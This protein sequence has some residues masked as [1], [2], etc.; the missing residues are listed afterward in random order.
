MNFFT[1]P[2]ITEHQIIYVIK[3]EDDWSLCKNPQTSQLGYVPTGYIQLIVKPQ[4]KPPNSQQRSPN[5]TR[6]NIQPSE[7]PNNNNSVLSTSSSSTNVKSLHNIEQSQ[8]QFVG[9]VN[10]VN[11]PSSSSFTINVEQFQNR[12]TEPLVDSSISIRKTKKN[13]QQGG[14]SSPRNS[15]NIFTVG[16]PSNSGNPH[17]GKTTK[18]AASISASTQNNTGG[19]VTPPG[20]DYPESVD[21]K[22][23]NFTSVKERIKLL[24]EQK[25]SLTNVAGSTVGNSSLTPNT[26]TINVSKTNTTTNA[27]TTINH[28]IS[29][30][31]QPVNSTTAELKK[32]M[33]QTQLN[34]TANTA[35]TTTSVSTSGMTPREKNEKSSTP[36]VTSSNEK[37]STPQNNNNSSAVTTPHVSIRPPKPKGYQNKHGEQ[38]NVSTSSTTPASSTTTNTGIHSVSQT[39][40]GSTPPMSN[41]AMLSTSPTSTFLY[42]AVPILPIATKTQPSR[43]V[44]ESYNMSTASSLENPSDQ[45]GKSPQDEKKK[46]SIKIGRGL[47]KALKFNKQPTHS[48]PT[49]PTNEDADDEDALPNIPVDSYTKSTN[50]VDSSQPH[51]DIPSPALHSHTSSEASIIVKSN[52][53][54][55]SKDLENPEVSDKRKTLPVN[56]KSELFQKMHSQLKLQPGQ[57]PMHLPNNSTS[58]GT[59]SSATTSSTI[60][61][62]EENDYLIVT[63]PPIVKPM[64]SIPSQVQRDY[65]KILS[66]KLRSYRK[67]QAMRNYLQKHESLKNARIRKQKLLE[68]VSTERDYVQNI[69][70][71]VDEF[72]KPMKANPKKYG[73]TEDELD[74]LFLNI[75]QI[76]Q[77]NQVL[78]QKLNEQVNDHQQGKTSC[79]KFGIVFKEMAVWFKL[80]TDYINNHELATTTHDVL[81]EKKKKFAAFMEKQQ[82][83]PKCKN[84]PLA[85]YL[86]QPVQRIPRYSKYS[87]SCDN[88]HLKN[89]F[90]KHLR[91]EK[92]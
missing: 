41:H 28:T 39:S 46:F 87:Y 5:L 11:N 61:S 58:T 83:N 12:K 40:F 35:T 49:P 71:C 73:V 51:G 23:G 81:M 67:L 10:S 82:N 90:I 15:P 42:G 64:P 84:L 8:Q 69:H 68:I 52:S 36:S 66:E 72:L 14:S 59:V 2:T 70:I 76:L 20:D 45:D 38:S 79:V 63:S 7:Q 32:R 33:P 17:Q 37:S 91:Y 44:D 21:N 34:Y 55:S 1:Q 22:L 3:Y 31:P 78:L 60:T 29:T 19:S 30:P 16:N 13:Q 89:P 18:S 27:T 4:M 56:M 6:K 62:S 80:Y 50:K 26:P 85:A 9:N 43:Q 53:S 92:N 77:C 25:L 86:I 57:P 54:L 88:L 47:S 65:V 48:S 75:N 24:Q 74:I